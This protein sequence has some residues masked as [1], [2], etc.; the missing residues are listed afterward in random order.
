ML[1][2]SHC[3]IQSLTEPRDI[4]QRHKQICMPNDAFYRPLF[5]NKLSVLSRL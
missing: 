2:S 4:A 1:P 3:F 5:P